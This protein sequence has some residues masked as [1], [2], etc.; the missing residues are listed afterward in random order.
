MHLIKNNS[1]IGIIKILRFTSALAPVT[2]DLYFF[3]LVGFG[4]IYR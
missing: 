3:V 2:V 4:P 1:K